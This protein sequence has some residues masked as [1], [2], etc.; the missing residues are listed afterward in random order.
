VVQVRPAVPSAGQS[1]QLLPFEP[2]VIQ[3]AV[4]LR[5][6]GINL[7]LAAGELAVPLVDC[8]CQWAV[9]LR[10]Q[11]GT[12]IACLVLGAVR[13]WTA[14]AARRLLNAASTSP[15]SSKFTV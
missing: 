1:L 5:Q 9:G 14:T 11:R 3:P 4:I 2:R 7:V 6:A 10:P 13:T 15:S 12:A 8:P